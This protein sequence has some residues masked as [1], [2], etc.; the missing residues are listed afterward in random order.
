MPARG[1]AIP[2]LSFP[3][4]DI[5]VYLDRSCDEWLGGGLDRVWL[6]FGGVRSLDSKDIECHLYLK[7]PGSGLCFHSVG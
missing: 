7:I 4:I 1:C 2:S 6:A 3:L 5:A